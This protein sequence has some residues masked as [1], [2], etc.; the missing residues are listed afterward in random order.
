MH[1]APTVEQEGER[2]AVSLAAAAAAAESPH[3]LRTPTACA[4][5]S[6][7]RFSRLA[8]PRASDG[9]PAQSR[10]RQTLGGSLL[11]SFSAALRAPFFPHLPTF[12]L[13][14][15]L[16][17]YLC[18]CNRRT[19]SFAVFSRTCC[20]C[21]FFFSDALGSPSPAHSLTA[22]VC[23]RPL[24]LINKSCFSSTSRARTHVAAAARRRVKTYQDKC[25]CLDPTIVQQ[26]AA[27]AAVARRA[28]PPSPHAFHHGSSFA[29][30][31]ATCTAAA[32]AAADIASSLPHPL[33]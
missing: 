28:L 9:A 25:D 3:S 1:L 23:H 8:S 5:S 18:S 32:T 4:G 26:T 11:F 13:Q 27:A 7:V 6:L 29:T 16:R 14:Q 31:T 20:R 30:T 2:S 17:S 21:C 33:R 22:T 24:A 12:F 10:D 15:Q 19:S